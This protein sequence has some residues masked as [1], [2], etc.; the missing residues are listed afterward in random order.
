MKKLAAL[1]LALFLVTGT[2]F[3]DSPKDSPKDTPKAAD[4]PPAKSLPAKPAAEKTS[5]EIAAEVELLRQALQSQ[6]EELQLLK[7]ELSKRDRQIE[8]AR[9]TAASANSR[10][11]EATVKASEAA[12]TSAE[13]KSTTTALNSTVSSMNTT[14]HALTM[15]ATPQNSGSAQL[16]NSDDGPATIRYKGVNLT[17]GGFLAAETVS[18]T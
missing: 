5:A 2:A 8:E 10:A 15:E 3:A 13:L 1:T 12:A 18:R 7:E 9:E 17:P 6:Q 14:V 11:T 16:G 4:A